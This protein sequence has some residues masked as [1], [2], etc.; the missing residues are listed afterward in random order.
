MIMAE[1]RPDRTLGL[2]HDTFW[3]WC[4]KGEL[5]IQKCTGCGHL[6]WPVMQ[7]CESCG[8]RE[9]SWELMSGRGKV[10]SGGS[11]H[12]DYYHAMLP[13]PY[14]CILVELEEGPL[15]MSNPKGFAWSDATFNMAVKLAFAECEDS[16]GVFSLPVF[17]RA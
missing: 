8:E 16:A 10:V 11:F 17:E 7:K 4:G 15:F 13:V 2:H 12:M 3:E 6:N 14:D 5:R 1:K 9:F